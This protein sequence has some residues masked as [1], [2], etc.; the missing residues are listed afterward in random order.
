MTT[1]RLGLSATSSKTSSFSVKSKGA[2]NFTTLGADAT[3]RVPQEFLTKE[4]SSNFLGGYYYLL[5]YL[6]KRG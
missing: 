1:T 5:K 3:P 4:L 2:G 6:S